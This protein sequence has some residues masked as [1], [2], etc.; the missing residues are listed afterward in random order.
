MRGVWRQRFLFKFISSYK[1]FSE[2]LITGNSHFENKSGT[3]G[4]NVG[5]AGKIQK[6]VYDIHWTPH[7][8]MHVIFCRLK[9]LN[10]DEGP[11]RRDSYS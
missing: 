5:T 10:P 3:G 2:K 1:F 7:L 4:A 11:K 9:T 8:S 6:A